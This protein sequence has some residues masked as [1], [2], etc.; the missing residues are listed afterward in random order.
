MHE[1]EQQ[2]LKSKR[3]TCGDGGDDGGAR[4]Q[5][6]PRRHLQRNA[7]GQVLVHSGELCQGTARPLRILGP[8]CHTAAAAVVVQ[9]EGQL[10]SDPQGL[11]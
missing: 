4:Q 8:R 1:D 5:R 6:A 3:L 7:D 2:G 9:C 10:R 11:Q